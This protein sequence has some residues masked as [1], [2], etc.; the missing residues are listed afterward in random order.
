MLVVKASIMMLII[1]RFHSNQ[2]LHDMVAMPIVFNQ[3]AL[4]KKL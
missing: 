1:A 4:G 2:V 3:V